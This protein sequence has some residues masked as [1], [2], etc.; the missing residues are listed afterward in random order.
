MYQIKQN[1]EDFIVIEE[2][3]LETKEKGTY[4]YFKLWT[5]DY[6]MMNALQ[7]IADFWRAPLKDIGFA[8]TKDKKAITEQSI[9][10]KN[11]SPKL[12]ENFKHDNIK[13]TFLGYG[14]SPISLGD[15]RGNKFEIVIRNIEL[16]PKKVDFIIN[17]FD[18]QRFSTNNVAVGKAM[19]KRKFEEAC[20]II[21]EHKV[22]EYLQDQPRNFVEAL[23]CVPFKILKLYVHSFQ[24]W[25]WNEAV[26][27][28]LQCKYSEEKLS[29]LK[30]SQGELVFPAEKPEETSFP[31]VGFGTDYPNEEIEDIYE[32]L[33]EKEGVG[34]RDF[35]IRAMPDLSSEGSERDLVVDVQDLEIGQLEDDELNAGKKKCKVKFFLKKGSYATMVVKKI[36]E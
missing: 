31:I 3:I 15:L 20:D 18:E 30:Y 29:K 9:S 6:T 4:A 21:R 24:S 12:A 14:D 19:I 17:Y 16:A 10:V 2:I 7:H 36:M 5:K 35:I 23:K 34:E 25:L 8:G 27:E 33:L 32:K 26:R 28:Y 22:Q 1:P 13:L 11:G